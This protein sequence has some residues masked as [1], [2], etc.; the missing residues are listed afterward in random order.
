MKTRKGREIQYSSQKINRQSESSPSWLM[1]AFPVVIPALIC[2]ALIF[3]LVRPLVRAPG[4]SSRSALTLKPIVGQANNSIPISNAARATLA[5]KSDTESER[6][7]IL[8]PD[9]P[10]RVAMR[11]QGPLTT[12]DKL[13]QVYDR[14]P[15]E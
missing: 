12:G 13:R 2:Y 8:P 6:P 3:L 5:L 11:M 4:A 14:D 9:S 10:R 1:W 15:H 7:D